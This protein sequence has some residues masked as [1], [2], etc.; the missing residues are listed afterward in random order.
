MPAT[1]GKW[2]EEKWTRARRGEDGVGG[3]HP[4]QDVTQVMCLPCRRMGRLRGWQE[5]TTKR[6]DWGANTEH[7]QGWWLG[8]R[9]IGVERE[10]GF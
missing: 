1:C 5:D 7:T 2:G 4:S 8:V 3:G 9:T 6:W 10:P